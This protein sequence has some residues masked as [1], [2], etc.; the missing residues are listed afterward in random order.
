MEL[1]GLR[2]FLAIVHGKSF[3][4]A[5]D[6]LNRTQ[7]AISRR[8][9]LLEDELGVRLFERGS[10]GITL[11]QAGRVLLPLAERAL[12]AVKDAG[13]AVKALKAEH[14]G[15]VSL[16]A[17]GTLAST[18]L[19][20]VL[21]RFAARFPNVTLTLSTASSADVSERV[22][23]GEAA[24]GLRYFNDPAPD[25]ICEPLTS[26]RLVVICA[27]GHRLAAKRVAL[28]SLQGESWFA[29]PDVAGQSELSVPHVHALF[30]SR[31]LGQLEWTPVD[32]LTAQKRLV[33][34]GFG[35]ALVPESAI[36]E[37]IARETLV[38]IGVRDLEVANPIVIVLRKDGYLTGAAKTLL[39]ILRAEYSLNPKRSR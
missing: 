29:F 20:V 19:T 17:V 31:G 30:K 32:S 15:P 9:A 11:S 35:L 33:E 38:V 7:P 22:R 13:E 6:Q 4:A 24:I 8:I 23:R 39:D 10:G 26:E 21:K 28:A 2:A 36:A 12:A 3:S 27:H 25:L 34:A 5:A 18:S 37:E 1:D 16:V 14:L